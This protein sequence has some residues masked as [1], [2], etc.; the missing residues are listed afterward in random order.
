M[1][2]LDCIHIPVG[3]AH[4]TQNFSLHE[5]LIAW[6]V[7][8][9][10]APTRESVSETFA[11]VDRGYGDSKEGDPEHLV[12]FNER[13][14]YEFSP[15]VRFVDLFARRFGA[16]GI[17]GGYGELNPG[18]SVP[19]RMH[20]DDE[21]ITILTGEMVCE[22]AGEKIQLKGSASLFVPR[23]TQHRFFNESDALMSMLWAR[24]STEYRRY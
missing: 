11:T 22:L 10:G 21:S 12:R 2:R 17:E 16:V 1:R 8:A 4:Q 13:S 5:P 15:G 19:C 23:G 3:H 7:F 20:D 24:A 14:K 9:S 18:S 6:W